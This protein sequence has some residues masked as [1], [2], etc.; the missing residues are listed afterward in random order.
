MTRGRATRRMAMRTIKLLGVIAALGLASRTTAV[1]QEPRAARAT[2]SS[3]IRLDRVK[4]VLKGDNQAQDFQIFNLGDFHLESGKTLPGAK[5]AYMT[6]GTLNADKSN[7]ILLPS[8]YSA[9]HHGYDYLIGP[10]KVL[11]PKK[12]FLILT[13][14]FANGLSSSPSNTPAP[15]NGPDFP[16]ISIRDNVNATHD[17]VTKQFEIDKLA[18]VIGFSMGAQQACQ[19]GVSFPNAMRAVVVICGNAKQYPFGIVRLQGSITALK[20]DCDWN[21]GRYTSPPEKGLRAMGAHYLAWVRSPAAW[22]RDLFKGFTPDDVSAF[23]QSSAGGFL[24]LD[25]NNLLSQAETWKRHNVGDTS[26]FGGD[27]EKALKSIR[28]KVLLMP[29]TTDQYFL[30]ADNQYEAGFIPNVKFAPIATIFGH[31]GGGGTDQEATKFI[32]HTIEEFLR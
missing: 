25:A 30:L 21:N 9:D 15:L 22:D 3:R 10:D 2:Q 32:S 23:L 12:Y 14:M 27:H 19:W 7:A 4:D 5:L 1:A 20:A 8:H 18:A 13:N 24:L 31:T 11:D 28:A 16:E 17:L 29:S 26:G 6:M